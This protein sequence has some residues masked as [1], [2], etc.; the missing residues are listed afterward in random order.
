MDAEID[1]LCSAWLLFLEHVRLMLVV[2]KLDDGLP[3]VT[4]VDIVAESR[5]VDDGKTD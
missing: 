5:S 1:L 2:E 4:V 3:R